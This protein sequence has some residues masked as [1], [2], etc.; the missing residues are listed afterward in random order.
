MA[1]ALIPAAEAI[2]W[3]EGGGGAVVGALVGAIIGS[4]IPFLWSMR[5]RA[6]ERRGELVAMRVEMYHARV[7]M[8][9]LRESRPIIL[10]PLYHIPLTMFDRRLPKPIGESSL[11]ENEISGLVEYVMRAEELNR[12]LEH[13]REAAARGSGYDNELLV[14]QEYNRKVAKVAII[15]DNQDSRLESKTVFEVAQ[16][17]LYRLYSG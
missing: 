3:W 2:H 15:L 10:A 8:S 11:T 17:A 13:A 7:A 12:G 4:C 14:R 6:V 1:C 5:V 9:E 16:S